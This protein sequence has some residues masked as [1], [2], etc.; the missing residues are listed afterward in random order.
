MPSFVAVQPVTRDSGLDDVTYTAVIPS[1]Q[2]NCAGGKIIL[3][4]IEKIICEAVK[5][6]LSCLWR[7]RLVRHFLLIIYIYNLY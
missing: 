6:H 3:R 1:I 7:M 2:Y 5:Q 4:R